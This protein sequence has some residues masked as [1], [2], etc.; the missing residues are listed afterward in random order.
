[1]SYEVK[2]QILGFENTA[3]VNI[4]EVDGL[5]S[6]MIDADN[7]NISF[8]MVNPYELR[9]YS[10]DVP[11]DLKIL[12]DINENSHVNVYNIVVI[13]EPLEKSAINF[14]API[15]VNEDNKR[16]GQAVLNSKTHPDFGMAETIES[17][18]TKG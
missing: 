7:K 4:N 6:T 16:V 18:K 9:E 8:T 2:G 17:F 15:I 12:L 1:M 5:F 10:F 11:T 3:N 14:L 13:Q